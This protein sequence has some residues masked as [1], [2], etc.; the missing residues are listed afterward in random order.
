MSRRI[1]V[2]ILKHGKSIRL[3]C[4]QFEPLREILYVL[5]LR[6]STGCHISAKGTMYYCVFQKWFAIKN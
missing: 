6:E 1:N 5:L 4:N 3:T 2:I